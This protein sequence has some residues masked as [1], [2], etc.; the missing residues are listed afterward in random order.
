MIVSTRAFG[1]RTKQRADFVA[2]DVCAAISDLLVGLE[3]VAA[4]QA[5]DRFTADTR[6]ASEVIDRRKVHQGHKDTKETRG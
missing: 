6:L 1:L 5:I 4:D 3:P 2:I